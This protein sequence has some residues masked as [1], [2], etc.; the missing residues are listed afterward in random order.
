M[1]LVPVLSAENLQIEILRGAASNNNARTG[2]AVTPAVRVTDA[3]GKPVAGALVIFAAPPAGPSVDFAGTGPV[4]HA[5][6]DELGAAAAPH[7]RPAG[8]DGPVQIEIVAEKGGDSAQASLFQ[9][10]LGLDTPILATDEL[11][12]TLI[13]IAN[14]ARKGDRSHI[15]LRVA[16][17]DEI[18]APGAQVEC[19]VR[20][21]K[22]SGESEELSRTSA[23]SKEE[24]VAVCELNRKG[25][26]NV[27]LMVRVSLSGQAATRYFKLNP[28]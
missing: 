11:N 22:A 12:V 3:K 14:P 6:T 8:G 4:A 17:R 27:E 18:P 7:V 9:M 25:G 13:G 16:G 28:R 23:L 5:Q 26:P 15:N 2:T 1:S 19:T 21:V 20:A 10:N 24:G